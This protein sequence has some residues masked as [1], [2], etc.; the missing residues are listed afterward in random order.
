VD[1][2]TA[3]HLLAHQISLILPTGHVAILTFVGNFNA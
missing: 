2:A 1:G 3:E